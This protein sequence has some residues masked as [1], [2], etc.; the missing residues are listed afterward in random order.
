MMAHLLSLGT[1][2]KDAAQALKTE[3]YV[4]GCV[5]SSLCVSASLRARDNRTQTEKEV[6]SLTLSA[7]HLSICVCQSVFVTGA[8]AF[9]LASERVF[10]HILF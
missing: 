3:W 2:S 7:A 6:V 5:S 10:M 8:P 4:C 9:V 1:Q